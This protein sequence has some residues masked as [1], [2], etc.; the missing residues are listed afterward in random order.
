MK[1]YT[2]KNLMVPLHEYATVPESATLL[3]AVNALRS[4]QI[5][6]DQKRNAHRAILVIGA[7]DHIVGKVSQHDVIEALEPNY[8]KMRN[9]MEEGSVHR[10]GFSETLIKSTLEQYHLWEKP[11][12]RLCRKAFDLSVKNIMYTP[13]KD[14][15]VVEHTTLDQAIHQMILCR[16]HSL[17]VTADPD[18][19][20]IVGVL[21]LIDIF[22]FVGDSMQA[23]AQS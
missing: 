9:T 4:A 16:H 12:D 6:F 5:A 22:R 23:C 14:E 11:L 19:K 15:F 13:A 10:L 8:K 3:E 17:L 18:E 7:N 2:V 1:S 20:K 21:R